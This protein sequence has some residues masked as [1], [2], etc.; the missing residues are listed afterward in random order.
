MKQKQGGW[1]EDKGKRKIKTER[2]REW[3]ERKIK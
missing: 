3:K 1:G 2:E